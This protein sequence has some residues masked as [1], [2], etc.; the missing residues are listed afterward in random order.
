MHLR[1]NMRV[2]VRMHVVCAAQ[3][4]CHCYGGGCPSTT[5]TEQ[6]MRL[7]LLD[8]QPIFAC[9]GDLL[10]SIMG[11]CGK[12]KVSRSIWALFKANLAFKTIA[13]FW[14]KPL[15]RII[16]DHFEAQMSIQ[17]QGSDHNLSHHCWYSQTIR[18]SSAKACVS[19]LKVSS[20]R[21]MRHLVGVIDGQPTWKPL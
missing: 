10:S 17:N 1:L 4:T 21:C 5:P 2:H 7:T 9:F 6:R 8:L 3:T 19:G 12:F 13:T 15:Y 14:A 18:W 11:V 20:L 16:R